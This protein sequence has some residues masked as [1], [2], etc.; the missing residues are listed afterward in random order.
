MERDLSFGS[1]GESSAL[2]HGETASVVHCY[3]HL[4]RIKTIYKLTQALLTN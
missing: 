4:L 3:F 1:N 2:R